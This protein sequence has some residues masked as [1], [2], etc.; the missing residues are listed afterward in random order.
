METPV[1]PAKGIVNSIRADEITG[2]GRTIKGFAG[3]AA[4]S[5]L[6]IPARMPASRTLW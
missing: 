4:G 1:L 5:S 3:T 2:F 6:T